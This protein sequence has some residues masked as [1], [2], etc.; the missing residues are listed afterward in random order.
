MGLLKFDSI[1]IIHNDVR[2][3]WANLDE[4]K[5]GKYDENDPNDIN[6]LRFY[7]ESLNIDGKGDGS[8]DDWE[9]IDDAS[10][11]TQVPAN[12]TN[13]E[14]YLLLSILMSE[15]YQKV[16]DCKSIN[17]LCKRLS[18]IHPSWINK[19]CRTGMLRL[20]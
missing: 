20:A 6:M 16:V 10:H 1:D 17:E 8:E 13:F 9:Q 15:I 2:I 14:L 4:G 11:C 3:E 18:L 5:N 12:T 7:V 19:R